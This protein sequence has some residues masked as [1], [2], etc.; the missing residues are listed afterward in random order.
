MHVLLFGPSFPD[1]S[2]PPYLDVLEAGLRHHGV[3]VERAG[4]TAF[5][6]DRDGGGFWPVDRILG[7]ARA[8]V[9]QVDL[10]RYDV[11]SLHFG[12]L[13]VDQL[14]AALWNRERSH[15]TPVVYH[16]HT[17]DP[18]LLRTQRPDPRWYRA[19]LDAIRDADGHVYF[20][21]YGRTRR[22]PAALPEGRP[23]KV[24]WLPTTIPAGTR[25]RA[26]PA[27]AAALDTDRPV[28]SLYGYAAPW[29]DATLLRSAISRMRVPARVVLAGDLWDDPRQA[30]TDLRGAVDTPERLGVGELVVVPGYV[31]AADRL[32]LVRASEAGVFPYRAHPSFQGSGAIADYLA[33]GVPVVTT[34]V[35]N[36]A[37]LTGGAG[38]TVPA[39]DD[40]R[41]AGAL[42]ILAVQSRQGALARRA[43]ERAPLFTAAAHARRCLTVYQQAVEAATEGGRR[44]A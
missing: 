30:G 23:T 25:P 43:R 41:L 4:S 9:D 16:V 2:L 38:I 44:S 8:L 5:P 42:D 15:R 27:L 31:G 3:T 29:K 18:T 35:A 22:G 19:V 14:V 24:S 32:T 7:A 37:E 21:E 33:H 10:D 28:L 6:Y 20:G 17:L 26:R 12:N 39:H 13:E 1:G 36:M 11:V 34:Q 40:V